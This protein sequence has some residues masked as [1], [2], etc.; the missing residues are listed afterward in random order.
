M[1]PV[2][3]LLEE[4]VE[5]EED[6]IGDTVGAADDEYKVDFMPYSTV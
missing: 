3:E 1:W 5:E 6:A 4:L 2:V